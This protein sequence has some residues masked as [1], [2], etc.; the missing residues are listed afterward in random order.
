[1]GNPATPS[2]PTKAKDAAAGL[3]AASPENRATSRWRQTA[4]P[5]PTSP[6]APDRP[7]PAA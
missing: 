1:M 4:T 7:I 3:L 6:I 2:A 5:K